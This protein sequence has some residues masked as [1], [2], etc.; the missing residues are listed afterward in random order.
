[1]KKQLL[2]LVMMLL[3]MVAS[4][5][6]VEINGIY[7]NLVAKTRQAEVTSNQKKKYSGEVVIPESIRYDDAGYSV[8]SIGELAFIRCI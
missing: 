5:N 3:P 4:A 7:Y 8:T 6:A 2:L 1:M